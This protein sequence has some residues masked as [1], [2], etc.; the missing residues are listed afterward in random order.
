MKVY[1][2][3]LLKSLSEG[4]FNADYDSKNISK[5][6]RNILTFVTMT[7]KVNGYFCVW[8]YHKVFLYWKETSLLHSVELEGTKT[9]TDRGKKGNWVRIE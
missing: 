6:V 5:N 9:R 2:A 4:H 7:F 8:M 1:T 3:F